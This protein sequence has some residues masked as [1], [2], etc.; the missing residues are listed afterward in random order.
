[1]DALSDIMIKGRKEMSKQRLF[2]CRIDKIEFEMR[3]HT[4]RIKEISE[5]LKELR[6]DGNND[7][8]TVDELKKEIKKARLAKKDAFQNWQ[9]V[10][11]AEEG[12]RTLLDIQDN[13]EYT[14]SVDLTTHLETNNVI[15]SP[16]LSTLSESVIARESGNKCDNI[17]MADK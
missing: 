11:D 16:S 15:N 7:Q 14:S 17:V 6:E 3:Y 12:R 4:S 5:E 9:V 8:D 1:M 2:K 13:D 10:T